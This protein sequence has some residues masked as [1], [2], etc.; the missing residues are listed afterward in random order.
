VTHSA[1]SSATFEGLRG[2]LFGLAYRMLGSRADAEDIVQE[3]YVRWHEAAQESGDGRSKRIENPEAWLVTTT[4]RLAIDR[5][6]RLKTE[7]E[8]Y[9]GP[10]LPE[11]ILTESA[12]DRH[13]DLADDLSMAF[14]T[15][16]ER[17][18][19]EERAA[20]LL[21]DV[22]DVGYTT[23]AS[24]ID[25]TEAACRQVVHRARERVRGDRKRFDATEAAKATLLQKFLA[26][27]EARDEQALLAL[28]APD[29]TWTADGG[30]KTAAAPRPIVGAARIA[31]LVIGLREKFW[32]TN[33]TIEIATINGETGLR[34]RDGEHLTAVM[35]IATDGDRIFA[36]YA[37]VN[38]EKLSGASARH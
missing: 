30:G 13:L 35:S 27:M 37:V 36:V 18:A 26:A 31:H 11:P 29:A 9:V 15:I 28:F 20:F 5:L 6:R 8:A 24:V 25:R 3:A 32:A 21:H 12:P 2:R 10:W 19:P 7:R 17:L 16:L 1:I 33:R 22:F 4:S 23:I 14:L 34:I 38:P